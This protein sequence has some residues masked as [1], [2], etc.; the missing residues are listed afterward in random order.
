MGG[1]AAV[2]GEAG[3]QGIV[4]EILAAAGAIRAMAAGPAQP[5]HADP[6]A[7]AGDAADDL[8]AGDDRQRPA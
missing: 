2:A 4:A 8:V 7:G 1:E 5:G 6:L 3:E